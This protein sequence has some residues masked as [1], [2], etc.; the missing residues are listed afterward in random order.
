MVVVSDH[1][2]GKGGG[3]TTRAAA[4]PGW[5]QIC[6]RRVSSCSTM[7]PREEALAGSF[8]RSRVSSTTDWYRAAC[9]GVMVA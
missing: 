9:A 7:R 1:C 5:L 8:I 2:V 6:F 4:V 3:G